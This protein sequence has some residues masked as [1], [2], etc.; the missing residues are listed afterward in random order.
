MIVVVV[1]WSTVTAA[2]VDEPQAGSTLE[3]QK[4]G[5]GSIRAFRSSQRIPPAPPQTAHKT[6]KR[7][8]AR[9]RARPSRLLL[10]SCARHRDFGSRE[11]LLL[12]SR[13]GE[14]SFRRALPVELGGS[15]RRAA[16]CDLALP[17]W[18]AIRERGN[19]SRV[20]RDHVGL[21]AKPVPGS[22]R[23]GNRG[24]LVTRPLT[25]P[26]NKRIRNSTRG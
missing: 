2:G 19:C 12:K 26:K 4:I 20:R 22:G 23:P 25:L 21:V 6:I 15:R 9:W 10:Q 11:H 13:G 3:R 18:A 24:C 8:E 17:R 5:T 7:P 1:V 14:S 16:A